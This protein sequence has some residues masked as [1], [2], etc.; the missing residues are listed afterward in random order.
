[1][2]ITYAE[3]TIEELDLVGHLTYLYTQ[4]RTRK[5]RI[6]DTWRRN[7]LLLC[8]RVWSDYRTASWMP[9][10]TDSEIYPIISSVAAWMTDQ[11]VVA[12][13]SPACDPNNPVADYYSALAK[14]LQTIV[15]S[16]WYADNWDKAVTLSI[17]DAALYGSGILKSVWDAGAEDGLG[18]AKLVRIDPFSFIPDPNASCIE[19]MEYCV[20]VRRMSYE[21][22][23]RRFPL[24]YDRV[25]SA[26]QR[27]SNSSDSDYDTRPSTYEAGQFPKANPGALPGGTGIYG[28]P[29]QSRRN[30]N[31]ETSGTIVYEFWLREN[32][33]ERIEDSPQHEKP[34]PINV[35][36]DMIVSDDWRVVVM[37]AGIILMDEKASDL[38]GSGRHPYSKFEFDDIGEFWGIPLVSHL[39][40]PQIAINRLLAAVQ[41]NAELTGNPVFLDSAGS[42]IS[43][44]MLVNR[45]GQRI[46][47]DNSAAA[48][49]FTPQWLTPPSVPQYVIDLIK[50]YI[51]RMENIS[52]LSTTNKGQSPPPRQ[53]GSTTVSIQE[54]GFVRI[55]SGLRNLQYALRTSVQLCCE[56]ITEN[57]TTPRYISIVGPS[58]QQSSMSLAARHFYDPLSSGTT[59]F[60]YALMIDCGANN[61]TSRSSR[62]AEADTL[63]AMGAIDAQA[64]LNAHLFPN[65][66]EIVARMQA[67]AATAAAQPRPPKRAAAGRKT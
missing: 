3:Q 32:H 46:T 59:P 64:V 60:K 22:I 15:E 37:A 67:A 7:Y 48:Q 55:R 27:L 6:Y 18:N 58:G 57:Y 25:L 13:I 21:E 56:L 44:T 24:A 35:Y 20:E 4:A 47:M 33:V 53:S 63:F 9:S 29:G 50:F 45:P 5:R 52:G 8:N 61:P 1:M 31:I 54:S 19:D 43:R 66:Q 23:Q 62:I 16:I 17:F 36:P 49:Q 38:W 41:Q 2:P 14:D 12:S 10:P 51:E 65:R 34:D 28:L 42:G 11:G 39:A 30:A 40:P 26:A